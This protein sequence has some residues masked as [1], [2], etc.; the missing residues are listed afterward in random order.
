FGLLTY[1]TTELGIVFVAMKRNI[2][3]LPAVLDLGMRFDAKRFMVT[4]VLPYTKEM[5][6][7]MLYHYMRQMGSSRP[8]LSLPKVEGGGIPAE[9]I[10]DAMRRTDASWG[11][12]AAEAGRDRCPFIEN[13][14]AA[15]SWDGSLSP[16]LPLMHTHTSYLVDYERHSKRYV[17]GNIVEKSLRDL[18]FDPE[19]IAFRQRVQS[20]DFSPCTYCGGCE[21]SV[22]NEADCA[23]NYFP[24]CGG[25]LWAQGL[26][27]C[28]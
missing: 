25:C 1:F 13:G 7:Q 2:A 5:S 16:C 22:D 18:W 9:M 20:F 17:I 21:L 11:G 15:I 27:Q 26:I 8:R 4:N 14:A 24:T 10:A 23:G 3:D 6:G 28:P 12:I 19:H